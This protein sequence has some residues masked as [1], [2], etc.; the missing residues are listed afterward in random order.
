VSYT[1]PTNTAGEAATA[2]QTS[3]SAVE[4]V[5]KILA[6]IAAAVGL[7]YVAGAGI[8]WVR[9]R[10][11]GLPTDAVVASLPRELLVAIGLRSLVAPTILLSL[12]AALVLVVERKARS[13]EQADV[14]TVTFTEATITLISAAVSVVLLQVLQDP[15]AYAVPW[16]AAV[17]IVALSSAY[18]GRR[19]GSR[20]TGITPILLA[21]FGIA[22]LS[23]LVRFGLE[24]H[25]PQL[26]RVRVCVTDV[27]KTYDGLF[28]GETSDR[29][30]VGEADDDVVEIPRSR[31]GEIVIGAHSEAAECRAPVKPPSPPSPSS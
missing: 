10:F 5:T 30:Y 7:V 1:P 22:L 12:V 4:T 16:A 20:L 9:L 13:P 3:G 21:A 31:V 14:A 28:I 23:A 26:E 17:A 29:V 15:E 8:L 2:G 19:F 27:K 24:A 11:E 25:N 18:V 6:A